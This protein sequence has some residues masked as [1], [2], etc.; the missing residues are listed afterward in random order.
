MAAISVIDALATP[1]ML[2]NM[3]ITSPIEKLQSRMLHFDMLRGNI[4]TK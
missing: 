1:G 2:V 4:M 3:S